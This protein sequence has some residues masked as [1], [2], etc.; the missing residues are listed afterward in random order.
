MSVYALTE[1]IQ[2]QRLPYGSLL[3]RLHVFNSPA[4]IAMSGHL[5]VTVGGK[6][7]IFPLKRQ[8]K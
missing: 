5:E 3:I 8:Q 2:G 7:P 1:E 6:A 4:G